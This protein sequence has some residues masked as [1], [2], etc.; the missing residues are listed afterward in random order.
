MVIIRRLV[1]VF[2]AIVLGAF[3]PAFGAE[4]SAQA[5]NSGPYY[6]HSRAELGQ[7]FDDRASQGTDLWT[8]RFHGGRNQQWI[9]REN[10]PGIVAISPVS[11]Q[12]KVVAAIRPGGALLLQSRHDGESRQLWQV[13]PLGDRDVVF[14][15]IAFRDQTITYLQGNGPAGLRHFERTPAQVWQ[16]DGVS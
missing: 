6:V 8:Y 9:L 1:V 5:A 12:D 11:N 14:E 2:T 13:H 3:L 15:S 16:I 10:R 7:V 4:A